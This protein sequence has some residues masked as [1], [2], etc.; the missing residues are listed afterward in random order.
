MWE[1]T[2]SRRRRGTY[3][4]AEIVAPFQREQVLLVATISFRTLNFPVLDQVKVV[5]GF[6]FG[7]YFTTRGELD[8][9]QGVGDSLQSTGVQP[10]QQRYL[11]EEV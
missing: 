4:L 1:V 7:D 10:L 3:H 11:L 6:S 5:S 2:A 8:A 9:L